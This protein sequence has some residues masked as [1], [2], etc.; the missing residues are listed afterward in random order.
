VSRTHLEQLSSELVVSADALDGVEHRPYGRCQGSG[1]VGDG[2]VPNE[3]RA[4]EGPPDQGLVDDGSEVVDEGDAATGGHQRLG[5]DGF[6]AVAGKQS[7]RVESVPGQ[8][9]LDHLG[10]AAVVGPDPGLAGKV[11]RIDRLGLS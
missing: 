7:D 5:L 8:D 2:H 3:S 11:G 9:L 4:A 1:G 6:V 10:G